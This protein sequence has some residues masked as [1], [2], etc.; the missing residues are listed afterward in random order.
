VRVERRADG[1][2]VV[3]VVTVDEAAAASSECGVVSTSV[4]LVVPA[5][6]VGPASCAGNGNVPGLATSIHYG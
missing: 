1:T 2:R 5:G 4:V 6:S 3:Q